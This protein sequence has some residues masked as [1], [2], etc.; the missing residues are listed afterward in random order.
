MNLN[1]RYIIALLI[2][3]G[4][5][6]FAQQD[7]VF[8]TLSDFLKTVIKN[9]P[10]SR[11]A[12]L[13]VPLA[14]AEV[15][16][17]RGA[18]DPE[19]SGYLSQKELKQNQYFNNKSAYLTI[20]TITGIDIKGGFENN[21]GPFV[22]PESGTGTNGMSLIGVSVPVLDGFIQN[23]RRNA[24]R[25][26]KLMKDYNQAEQRKALNTLLYDA[27]KSYWEWFYDFNKIK[28]FRESY[29][30]AADRLTFT[31]IRVEN[32]DAAPIDSVEALIQMQNFL[33]SYEQALLE[34]QN[35]T[36]VLETFLWNDSLQPMFLNSNVFPYQTITFI[37]GSNIDSAKASLDILVENHPENRK[38]E[39]KGK[40]LKIERNN[41]YGKL[42]PKFNVDAYYLNPGSGFNTNAYPYASNYKLGGYL[43]MPLFLF[44]E[45]GKLNM[46][47]LKIKDNYLE[48][49]DTRRQIRNSILSSLN[50]MRTYSNQLLLQEQLVV[51]NSKLRNAEQI[52]FRNGESSMFLI[53]QREMN[54]LTSRIKRAEILSKCYKSVARYYYYTGIF[55]DLIN[56][57]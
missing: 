4:Q 21:S 29:F 48:Q 46:T 13:L 50:E 11:Q 18:I 6:G 34:F 53:N 15:Q 40:Q 9:H 3:I 52:N 22:N 32:G 12:A 47:K 56:A 42:L 38:L 10:V 31:K 51:N 37:P 7:S 16:L 45:R 39:V 25:Q 41:A 30:M 2:L 49:I 28:I 19:L 20:P 1:K 57:N 43:S 55:S 54:L 44:E 36:L 35:Q 27:A 14:K 24:I 17:A 33:V 26:A 5:T 23:E 8:L